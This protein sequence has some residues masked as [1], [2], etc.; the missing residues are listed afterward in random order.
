[1][2]RA[3]KVPPATPSPAAQRPGA[4]APPAASMQAPP[5]S[6]P[7][8]V[9]A[10]VSAAPMRPF[11]PPKR[12][13]CFHCGAMTNTKVLEK[14]GDL[15]WRC[16]RPI[17]YN[18]LKVLLTICVLLIVAAAAIVGWQMYQRGETFFG[19]KPVT[20]SDETEQRQFTSEQK[21]TI[22][23]RMVLDGVS[24]NELTAEYELEPAQL[25]GWL[26]QLLDAGVVAFEPKVREPLPLEKRITALEQKLQLASKALAELREGLGQLRRETGQY[27]ASA[28]QQFIL[29]PGGPP[30]R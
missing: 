14:T 12:R 30:P 16:Y 10:T 21:M 19:S 15:C 11:K 20:S 7:P 26:K 4:S 8:E 22:I 1:M 24:A 3:E 6:P 28:S 25:R 23:R 17:G 18:I 27:E 5:A 29:E 13:P 2:S 9:G